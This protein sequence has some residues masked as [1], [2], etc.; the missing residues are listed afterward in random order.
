M[1]D[2]DDETI[3][4]GLCFSPEGLDLAGDIMLG[5]KIALENYEPEALEIANT[6]T[7]GAPFG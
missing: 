3:V 5:Q 7:A 2:T 6:F 4:T 1:L